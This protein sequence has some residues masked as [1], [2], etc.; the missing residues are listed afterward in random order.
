[1]GE[2]E[3]KWKKIE[4]FEKRHAKSKINKQQRINQIITQKTYQYNL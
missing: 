2:Q 4:Q 3:K 1:M